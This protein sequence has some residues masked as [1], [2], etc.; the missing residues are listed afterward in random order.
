M[1][2]LCKCMGLGCRNK[3]W[4]DLSDEEKQ[5]LNPSIFAEEQ[6]EEKEDKS[7]P[8]KTIETK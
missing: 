1:T 4:A 7:W 3:H 8:P 2:L 5:A 6:A